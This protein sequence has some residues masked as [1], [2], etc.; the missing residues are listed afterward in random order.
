MTAEPRII[1]VGEEPAPLDGDLPRA[2]RNGRRRDRPKGKYGS[3]GR[4]AVINA[5]ADAMLA[6]L[7]RA[8]LAVWLLLWRDTKPNGLA[9]TSQA[10]LA[11]R[12]GVNPRTVR[13]ALAALVRA[14]LVT[15]VH[16]G[17]LPSRVSA[18]RVYAP[19]KDS[20]RRPAH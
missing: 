3:G 18:Y 5:F 9:R 19:A 2:D 20:R 6:T 13:R 12:A 8:E 10:D 14:G 17:G 16:R 4:F 1:A 11:R 15:V 7:G